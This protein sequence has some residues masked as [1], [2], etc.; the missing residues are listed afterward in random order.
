MLMTNSDIRV[1]VEKIRRDSMAQRQQHV[2]QAVE[3]VERVI[4]QAFKYDRSNIAL[5]A[6]EL[7]LRLRGI[8]PRANLYKPSADD[9]LGRALFDPRED[10]DPQYQISPEPEPASESTFP[11][12][13]RPA[14]EPLSTPAPEGLEAPI[15]PAS[16][17]PP[18]AQPAAS[19]N[20]S[21]NSRHTGRHRSQR[22]API[23]PVPPGLHQ[24]L[25]DYRKTLRSSL[26]LDA[27]SIGEA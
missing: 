4:A 21:T 26:D 22:P 1:R 7:Q 14:A 3:R 8:D 16:P 27:D 19:A 15:S 13:P 17:P 2:D 6:I 10:E 12:E 11:P 18:A 23:P 24:A 20:S 9:D 5:K 25:I